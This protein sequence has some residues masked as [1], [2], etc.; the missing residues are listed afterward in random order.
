MRAHTSTS[1]VFAAVI[2]LAAA[3]VGAC[4]PL[5]GGTDDP[6]APTD[7]AGADTS[8]P[9]EAGRES[10][11]LDMPDAGDAPSEAGCKAN[12]LSCG[13]RCVPNDA[14][15][16]GACG[17]DCGNLAHVSGSVA[18]NAGQ[19]T[20][21][22]SACAAGF[23]N[24]NGMPDDGCEADLSKPAHCG[25]CNTTCAADGGSP[26]CAPSSD[27]GTTY[28]CVSGCPSNAPTLCNGSCVD[29]ATSAQNCMT[30]GHVCPGTSNGQATCGGGQCDVS[31]N[32]GFHK[33]GGVCADNASADS[34]GTS[35]CTPCP[36]GPNNSVRTCSGGQC[37]WQCA[38]GY[39]ACGNQCFADGDRTHTL[40]NG[41]CVD[42]TSDPTNCNTCGHTCGT[43]WSCT[44]S[45]CNCPSQKI[46]CASTHACVDTLSDNSNCGRCDFACITGTGANCIS[47]ACACPGGKSSCVTS[48]SL[49]CYDLAS[50]PLHCSACNA[51]CGFPGAICVASSCT[52]PQGLVN[53]GA[54]IGCVDLSM[55]RNNCGGCNHP[56]TSSQQ[57]ISGTCF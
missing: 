2:A 12:E 47:G 41:T 35:S 43:G 25:G 42:L 23:S 1:L 16:C 3:S 26:V 38:S 46:E 48:S 9:D 11:M 53:C 32:M 30:C 34:C 19:C 28:S 13:G 44:S 56:C 20:F 27:A 51:P 6:P 37:G 24:C 5:F 22:A 55:D 49:G 10:G 21:A 50:D 36:A 31:C 45:I 39:H 14:R 52:C 8:V 57:C 4:G 29:T 7:D 33:C 54:V 18:C 40:C 17:H 15:N